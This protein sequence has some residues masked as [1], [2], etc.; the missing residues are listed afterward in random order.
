MRVKRAACLAGGGSDVLKPRQFKAIAGKDAPRSIDK[1]LA[2]CMSPLLLAQDGN[3]GLVNFRRC[4]CI[5]HCILESHTLH[6]FVYVFFARTTCAER[7]AMQMQ[8][9]SEIFKEQQLRLTC[10]GGHAGAGRF[11][12]ADGRLQ[13]GAGRHVRS[14]GPM[15]VT[16]VKIQPADVPLKREWVGTLDGYVNA[17]IQPQVSGYLVRQ[18]YGEGSQ[19][20]KGDVL[21]EI[22]PASVPGSARSGA[23]AAWA[24]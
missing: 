9:E 13:V 4:F 7:V 22:D 10:M 1:L 20:E 12:G 17:Q 11:R 18:N 21:F 3:R 6:T 24:G 16:V 19:V 5:V 8:Q 15:P 23:R 2:R 14:R